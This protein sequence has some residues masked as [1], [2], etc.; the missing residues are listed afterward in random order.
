MVG[1]ARSGKDESAKALIAKGFEQRAFASELKDEICRTFGLSREQLEADKTIWRPL[2][3]EWGRG[4]RRLDADYWLKKVATNLPA[5]DTVITD[6]RYLNE[7][8]WVQ[9]L[10]GTLLRVVRPGVGPTNDEE[11]VT[12]AE[13]DFK[14]QRKMH[15]VDNGGTIEDLHKKV[16]AIWR[17]L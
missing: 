5:G 14:M 7:A 12:I 2:L 9:N 6:V 8:M 4:R 1:Y 15:V 3:V 13:I 17:N 16:E 11:R 10:G